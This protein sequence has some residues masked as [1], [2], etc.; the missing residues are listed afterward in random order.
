MSRIL[1]L[2]AVAFSLLLGSSC[3][4]AMV[5]GRDLDTEPVVHE[6]TAPYPEVFLAARQALRDMEFKVE[7]YNEEQ[8]IIRTGWMPVTSDSHYVD[9]FGRPDYGANG[10]Y[11]HF[12]IRMQDLGNKTRV[13]VQA[14]LRTIV[15]KM[16]SSHREE[17]RLL[18]RV[19]HLVRPADFKVTNVGTFGD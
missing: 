18:K 10:A 11:Y 4:K 14:P 2:I 9:V 8:G 1:I 17:N 16:Y 19:R 12:A 13:Q 5:T 15:A 3:N 6:F 7:Y